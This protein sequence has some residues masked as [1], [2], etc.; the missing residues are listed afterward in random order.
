MTKTEIDQVYQNKSLHPA[1]HPSTHF[2]YPSIHPI[3][4]IIMEGTTTCTTT[5][6]AALDASAA[7]TAG[8]DVVTTTSTT[9]SNVVTVADIPTIDF[10]PYLRNEGVIIGEDPTPNQLHVSKQIDIACRNHGFIYLINFGLSEDLRKKCFQSSKELFHQSPQHKLNEMNRITPQTNIGYSPYQS[11]QLNPLRKATPELKEA[12]NVRF[13]PTWNNDYRGCPKSFIEYSQQLQHVMK[14]VFIRY[15]YACSVALQLPRTFFADT[16]KELNLCTIRFLH[17]P[18]CSTIYN[19]S[20]QEEADEETETEV[21]SDEVIGNV[22][23]EN[24]VS[25]K[26]KKKKKQQEPIIRVGEH[27]DFGAYTFLLL[28]E[29]GAEGLQIKPVEGGEI[30]NDDDDDKNDD[31]ND[32]TA[33][34]WRDVVIP[35]EHRNNGAIINTGALMARWT[36]DIWKATAHR[37]IVSNSTYAHRERFSIA[38]F[39]DPDQDSIIDVH[40]QLVL[41]DT[42]NSSQE[43]AESSNGGVVLVADH[44]D[45]NNNTT[46]TTSSSRKKLKTKKYGPIKSSDY[47]LTKLTEMMSPQPPPPTEE[48]KELKS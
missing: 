42:I 12:F 31:D 47:L 48:N 35:A 26:Q 19:T 13:P 22:V 44:L 43:E 39:V 37:V 24:D 41:C 8:N 46:T 5:T 32:G 2:I 45:D 23:V 4:I 21:A 34:G 9:T 15:A 14:D 33:T 6:A 29:H 27:T 30:L 17:S 11:E 18:E 3:I 7:A 38:C 40:D 36:N 16:L 28:G 25:S 1:T 10:S 20:N